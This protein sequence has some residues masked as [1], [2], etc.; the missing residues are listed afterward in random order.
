[1]SR[2]LAA[3]DACQASIDAA[4]VA[5]ANLL[6]VHHGLFWGGLQ[7]VVGR[8][9]ARLRA[10]I[11][12]GVAVYS[13]HIPLDCHP[14][15]GN[16]AVLANALGLTNLERAGEYKGV[17]IGLVGSVDKT[18]ADFVTQVELVVGKTHVIPGGPERISRVGV[19]TGGAG[20]MTEAMRTAGADTFLTGEGNHHSFFDA[21]EGGINLIYA[22]HYATETFGVK[23]LAAHIERQFEIPWEFFDYPTGL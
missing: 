13:V 5:G 6:L 4:V 15:V 11:E 16:N 21:T 1:V 20:S 3:V 12:N 10:L 23:A 9:W 18:L 22:G 19:V 14:E 7:P 2:I 8:H 17:S